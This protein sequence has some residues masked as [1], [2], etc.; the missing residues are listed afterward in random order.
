[1]LAKQSILKSVIIFFILIWFTDVDATIY[2]WRDENGITHFTDN[3]L[4][5][6]KRSAKNLL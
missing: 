1:M 6:R 5:L 3:P 4:K 2:K